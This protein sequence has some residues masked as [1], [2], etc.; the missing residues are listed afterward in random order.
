M[1]HLQESARVKYVTT[2]TNASIKEE[3]AVSP[4]LVIKQEPVSGDSD[5][6]PINTAVK[7]LPVFRTVTEN[8]QEIIELLDSDN[9]MELADTGT[10]D[11]EDKGMSSD[12]MV[13]P[14]PRDFDIELEMDSD[15]EPHAGDQAK[16]NKTDSDLGLDSDN[17]S[18][19]ESDEAK[20][21]PARE[22]RTGGR[23][24]SPAKGGQIFF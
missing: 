8:G 6:I 5:V 18:D 12:T 4:N 16:S 9:E 3:R 7:S 20:G 1:K 14:G 21:V 2:S 15:D 22:S 13:G 10:S 19:S 17:D 24:V 23:L 11:S